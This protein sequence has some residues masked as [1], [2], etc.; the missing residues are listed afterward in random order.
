MKTFPRAI[1]LHFVVAV[2]P[3]TTARTPGCPTSLPRR[4]KR[5]GDPDDPR[6]PTQPPTKLIRNGEPIDT[7]YKSPPPAANAL[8]L[9]A[10]RNGKA[11]TRSCQKT[12]PTSASAPVEGR[13]R[14]RTA[15]PT[16]LI[17]FAFALSFFLQNAAQ[18]IGFKP[19]T[20]QSPQRTRVILGILVMPLA[21]T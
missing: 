1:P 2:L 3:S 7:A 6:R 19:K 15:K 17:A 8:G 4:G 14:S 20:T 11:F 9:L 18:K 16:A 10:L 13:E 5:A 21:Y 12:G